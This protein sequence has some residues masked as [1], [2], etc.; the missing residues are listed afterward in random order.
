MS[1]P[2]SAPMSAASSSSRA[3]ASSRGE[4]VTIRLIS[5]A[6]L[7]WVFCKPALNLAKRPVMGKVDALTVHVSRFTFEL[8]NAFLELFHMLVRKFHGADQRFSF[9]HSVTIGAAGH[10][11]VKAVSDF[12]KVFG[13]GSGMF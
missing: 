6:S 8:C 4:R 13:N 5:C 10:Q 9:A 7:L 3:E 2:R 1:I 11:K 12:Q